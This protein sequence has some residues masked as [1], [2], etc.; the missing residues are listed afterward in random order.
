[1]YRLHLQG[2][3]IHE[4]GTS[5]SMWLQTEPPVENIQLYKKREGGRECKPHGKSTEMREVESG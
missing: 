4:W 3:K 1:M 2:K 5:V